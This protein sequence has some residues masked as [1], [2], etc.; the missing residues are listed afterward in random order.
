MDSLHNIIMNTVYLIVKNENGVIDNSIIPLINERN[1]HLQ[2]FTQVKEG[3]T[4]G[5]LKQSFE[6]SAK[7]KGRGL[8]IIK[9]KDG[10]QCWVLPFTTHPLMQPPA[11]SNDAFVLDKE[12]Y[13]N[14]GWDV[15]EDIAY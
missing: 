15:I 2:T 6:E 14:F 10:V 7:E 12:S 1:G 8:E 3:D 13:I 5:R 11:N 4:W 9:E